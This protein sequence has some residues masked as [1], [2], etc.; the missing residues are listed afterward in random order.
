[1]DKIPP[2]QTSPDKKALL[3]GKTWQVQHPAG[4]FSAKRDS[5]QLLPR[6]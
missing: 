3:Q 2:M 5:S 4:G 1:M 6:N